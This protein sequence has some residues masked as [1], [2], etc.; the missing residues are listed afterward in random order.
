MK[1]IYIVI[2]FFNLYF[3]D[4]Q[5]GINLWGFFFPFCRSQ[6]H[7]FFP[8]PC[9]LARSHQGLPSQAHLVAHAVLVLALWQ[10]SKPKLSLPEHNVQ[11]QQHHH[12]LQRGRCQ[13]QGQVE[14]VVSR[15]TTYPA[16]HPHRDLLGYQPHSLV[17]LLLAKWTLLVHVAQTSLRST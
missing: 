7:E 9:H 13:A 8:C 14:A 6:Y 1:P 2:C 16:R 4:I 12:L 10:I 11:Q 3:L 15:H 5:M 17:Y